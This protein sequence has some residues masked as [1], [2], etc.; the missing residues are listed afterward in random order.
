MIPIHDTYASERFLNYWGG[1]RSKVMQPDM[2]YLEMDGQRISIIFPNKVY[3][4]TEDGLY[5]YQGSAFRYDL[6]QIE[7][8]Y[9]DKIL[10]AHGSKLYE[11]A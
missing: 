8:T 10:T 7:D 6:A 5:G 11:L 1:H 4:P 3:G 9:D 2:P